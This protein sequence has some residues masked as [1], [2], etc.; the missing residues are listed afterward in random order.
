M[1]ILVLLQKPHLKKHLNNFLKA[2]RHAE[3]DNMRGISANV[4]CGQDGYFG[5][6]SFKVLLDLNESY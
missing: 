6:S 5:T 1:M 3:L 2:A 4:M